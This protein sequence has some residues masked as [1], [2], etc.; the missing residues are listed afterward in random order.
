MTIKSVLTFG[1]WML[2]ASA[3]LSNP[4]SADPPGIDPALLS[5]SGNSGVISVNAPPQ[6][7][8]PG[9]TKFLPPQPEGVI[10]LNAPS[11]QGRRHGALTEFAK[12]NCTPET[13]GCPPRSVSLTAIQ[14]TQM[15]MDVPHFSMSGAGGI[16]A[17]AG[18]IR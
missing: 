13:A 1:C 18:R 2:L 11:Q 15:R 12:K 5:G 7:P 10:N 4:A 16:G 3:L 8:E 9:R 6:P 14:R 17:G